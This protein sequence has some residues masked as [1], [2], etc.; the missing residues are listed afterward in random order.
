MS[1]MSEKEMLQLLLQKMGAM[2][3]KMDNMETKMDN[4]QREIVEV[5]DAVKYLQ[6][7][8]ENE[9]RVNIKRVAEGHLDLARNLKAA[10]VPNQELEML[11]IVVN[12]LVTE[13]N[14]LKR[15]VS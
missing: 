10:Q 3:T 15:K 13:V 9:V 5:K 14:E 2:G 4:M 6:L 12:Q 7:T 8:I 1:E 11:T